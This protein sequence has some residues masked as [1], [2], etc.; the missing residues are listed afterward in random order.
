MTHWQIHEIEWIVATLAAETRLFL[1]GRASWVGKVRPPTALTTRIIAL[2]LDTPTSIRP[3]SPTCK[4]NTIM[5]G[6]HA[7]VSQAGKL[8]WPTNKNGGLM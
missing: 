7:A 1:L 4:S 2:L 5:A 8:E 6:R 3:M